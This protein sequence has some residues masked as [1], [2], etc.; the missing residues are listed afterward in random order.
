LSSSFLYALTTKVKY[1]K[2]DAWVG[3]FAS[4]K[5]QQKTRKTRKTRNALI[6]YLRISSKEALPHI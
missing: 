2:R 3:G 5:L 6:K 1:K 4:P